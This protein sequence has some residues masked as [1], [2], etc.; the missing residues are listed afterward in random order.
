MFPTWVPERFSLQLCEAKKQYAG[1]DFRAVYSAESG[2][3][4]LKWRYSSDGNTLLVEKSS[5][6]V[7]RLRVNDIVHY[8]FYD[9]ESCM[10]KAVWA[11]GNFN[12]RIAGTVTQGE[13]EQIVKSIYGR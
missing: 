11:N 6:D 1:I 10:E 12:C 5:Q 9:E 2:R 7:L 3:L 4:T 13:I 8:V